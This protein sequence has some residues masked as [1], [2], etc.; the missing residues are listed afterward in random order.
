VSY[1]EGYIKYEIEWTPGPAAFAAA[2]RELDTWRRPLFE[3]GLIGVYADLDIG[4]GNLSMRCGEPGQFLISG[5]QTGSLSE[6]DESHYS[7][8]TRVDIDANTVSCVGPVKASSEAMTHAAIYALDD[9]IGAIVHVHSR[10]LWE[11]YLDELPTTDAAIAY[12]T[13]EMAREFSR[14]FART[15][16]GRTGVAVMAGHDEGLISFGATIEDA[17]RRM[18]TLAHQAEQAPARNETSGKP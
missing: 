7:L 10:Q 11:R 18:L 4:Y 8:V 12:G 2:A 15:E 16:F 17:A 1:D 9:D 5:T 14:L 3:A 6:T 13:P